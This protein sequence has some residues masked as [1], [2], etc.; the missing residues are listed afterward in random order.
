MFI[1]TIFE[2]IKVTRLTFSQESITVLQKIINYQKTRVKLTSIQ[3]KNLKSEA[4]NKKGI[5]L[6]LNK[7]N[8]K[9]KN[10]YMNYF[11]QQGKLVKIPIDST[12]S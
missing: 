3:L 5:I 4:K 9:M 8:L 6:Q 7:K 10:C 1:L 12:T 2:E 11:K